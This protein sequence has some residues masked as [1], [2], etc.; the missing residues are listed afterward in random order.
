VVPRRWR[1]HGEPLGVASKISALLEVALEPW[2][3]DYWLNPDGTP[4]ALPAALTAAG[5][6]VRFVTT[7]DGA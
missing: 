4:T 3:E 5:V 1:R 7:E 6:Q 2:G